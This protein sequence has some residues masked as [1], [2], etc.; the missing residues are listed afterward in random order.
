[1]EGDRELGARE[2]HG[3]RMVGVGIARGC[4]VVAAEPAA[5]WRKEL[6]KCFMVMV[7]WSIMVLSVLTQFLFMCIS[8][9][10]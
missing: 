4:E 9:S 5:Q 7:G 10:L 3:K 1:M 6:V 8:R 2:T